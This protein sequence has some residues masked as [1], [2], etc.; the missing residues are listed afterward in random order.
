MLYRPTRPEKVECPCF[1]VLLIPGK[2]RPRFRPLSAL[3]TPTSFKFSLPPI[4]FL[5]HSEP[6]CHRGGT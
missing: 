1:F 3:L 2:I 6:N 5:Q 4:V